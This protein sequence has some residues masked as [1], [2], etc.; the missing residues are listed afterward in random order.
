MMSMMF[1]VCAVPRIGSTHQS[2]SANVS[3]QWSVVTRQLPMVNLA[4][5]GP[6]GDLYVD[7]QR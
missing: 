4:V 6:L 1:M 2:S 7:H 3:G 5:D